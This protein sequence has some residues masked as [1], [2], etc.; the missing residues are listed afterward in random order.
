MI[1]VS[2]RLVV[3]FGTQVGSVVSTAKFFQETYNQRYVILRLVP[4]IP[5]DFFPK[6][7]QLLKGSQLDAFSP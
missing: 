3:G 4:M 5:L 1:L 7:I 6:I 2:S